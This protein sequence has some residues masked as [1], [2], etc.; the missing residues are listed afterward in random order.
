MSD[1]RG[2]ARRNRATGGTGTNEAANA[3]ARVYAMLQ[4]LADERLQARLDA[5]GRAWTQSRPGIL[6]Q[7]YRDSD[8][9]DRT[10]RAVT[11]RFRI[12]VATDPAPR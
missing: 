9:H 5:A 7:Q 8:F 1:D 3:Q 6:V 10:K 12:P 11:V 4:S 2:R